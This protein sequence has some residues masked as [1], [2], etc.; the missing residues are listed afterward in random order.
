MEMGMGRE[1]DM[2][3]RMEGDHCEEGLGR[4]VILHLEGRVRIDAL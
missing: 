1:P 4:S 3:T 2:Y